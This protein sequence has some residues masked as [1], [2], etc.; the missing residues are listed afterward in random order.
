MNRH[1][2]KGILFMR[3]IYHSRKW[4]QRL[5]LPIVCLLR[6]SKELQNGSNCDFVCLQGHVLPC[7]CASTWERYLSLS[8]LCLR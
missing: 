8:G 5:H 3:I 7:G 1:L 2:R 4:Q 6:R